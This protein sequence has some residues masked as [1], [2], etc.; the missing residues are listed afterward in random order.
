[1]DEQIKLTRSC[2]KI[3][4]YEITKELKNLSFNKIYE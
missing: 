1:M 2:K 3:K 4:L